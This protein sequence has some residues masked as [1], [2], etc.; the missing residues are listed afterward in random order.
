MPRA[1]IIVDHGSRRDEANRMLDVLADQVR[2]ITAD[3]VYVAHMEIAEPT[4]T[5]A[6][7]A[8]VADG[9]DFVFV[10]PYFLSPGQHSRGD[11]PRMAADAAARHPGIEYHCSGPVGLDPIMAELILNRIQRCERNEWSC[12][13]C[14]DSGICMRQ[15]HGQ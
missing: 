6:F 3:C 4:I 14:P 11:I 2:Q 12:I 10:F 9:A 7:D 8:A 1:I 15:N 13:D 5:E